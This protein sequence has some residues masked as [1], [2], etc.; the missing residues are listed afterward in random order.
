MTGVS[1]FFT[2]L[3]HV[4]SYHQ[5]LVLAS[6]RWRT[7]YRVQL[8]QFEWNVAVV[9]FGLQG[10]SSLLMHVMNE[11]LTSGWDPRRERPD[12]WA[13]ALVYMDDC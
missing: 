12:R 4:S 10:S 6:D 2:K 9:P 11:A 13:G 5:L 1:C 7:S 3:N 8:G